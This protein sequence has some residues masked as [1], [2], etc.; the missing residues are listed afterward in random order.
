[1]KEMWSRQLRRDRRALYEMKQTRRE[2]EIA[3]GTDRCG[4]KERERKTFP[5]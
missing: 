5:W 2:R 4:E 3:C 1:M